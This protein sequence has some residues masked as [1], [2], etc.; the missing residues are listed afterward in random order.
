MFHQTEC[1][2]SSPGSW[3]IE[4]STPAKRKIVALILSLLEVLEL[5]QT[6]TLSPATEAL[7]DIRFICLCGDPRYE[8]H[9]DFQGLVGTFRFVAAPAADSVLR[10]LI[11]S[12][13]RIESTKR[14][15][16]GSLERRGVVHHIAQPPWTL[17]L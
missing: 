3:S 11:M 14:L 16:Q 2:L 7:R 4:S 10:S 8:G 12:S 17:G 6:A 13:P 5:P 1:P 15:N 9:F